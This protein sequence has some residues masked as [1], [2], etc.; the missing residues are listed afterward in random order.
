MPD[1][2]ENR[3][4]LIVDDWE[5]VSG[6]QHS[7]HGWMFRRGEL[8]GLDGQTPPSVITT[9]A[10]RRIDALLSDVI[11]GQHPGRAWES[12]IVLFDPF[13]MS[14]LDIAPEAAVDNARRSG[15]GSFVDV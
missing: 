4:L 10:A 13:G 15:I 1:T 2:V 9:P 5:L 12:D 8:I 3:D 11:N 7:M 14:M 6:D